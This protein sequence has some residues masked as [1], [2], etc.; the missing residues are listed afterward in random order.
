MGRPKG[1]RK[2]V[3]RLARGQ[4]MEEK[5]F[6]ALYANRE[7]ARF[8]DREAKRLL[9]NGKAAQASRHDD[10]VFD[11]ITLDAWAR[12]STCEE[13]KPIEHYMDEARKELA[14]SLKDYWENRKRSD[15]VYERKQRSAMPVRVD[16]ERR[17]RMLSEK[18]MQAVQEL[19]DQLGVK[20]EVV[21]DNIITYWRA[22]RTAQNMEGL[23]GALLAFVEEL[24]EDG[25]WVV[26]QGDGLYHYLV[27][28]RA[29]EY[30]SV[31]LNRY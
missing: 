30:Q 17:F 7:L 24:D 3:T 4:R 19:A 12:V 13:G 21:V 29:W 2:V 14:A 9:S 18:N 23:T 27:L 10:A 31:K 1:T 11:R 20:R 6:R 8:I 5:A 15:D 16:K 26:L 28:N 22:E 25:R